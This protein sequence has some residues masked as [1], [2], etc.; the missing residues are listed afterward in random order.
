MQYK[1]NGRT[2]LEN[3][4]VTDARICRGDAWLCCYANTSRNFWKR[5]RTMSNDEA[6]ARHNFDLLAINFR[7]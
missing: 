5:I 7:R 3:W 2:W 1:H 6:E 4:F